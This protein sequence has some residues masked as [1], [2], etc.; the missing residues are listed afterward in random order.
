MYKFSY[1]IKENSL[2]KNHIDVTKIITLM[3]D[4]HNMKKLLFSEEQ[5]IILKNIRSIYYGTF[6]IYFL[7]TDKEECK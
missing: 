1:T 4:V 2:I 6:I 7:Y 3:I 5:L